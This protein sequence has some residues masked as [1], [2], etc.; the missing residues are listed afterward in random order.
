MLD[1]MELLRKKEQELVRV[2]RQVEALR[3][4]APLLGEE[5]QTTGAITPATSREKSN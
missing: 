4:A 3:I 5:D 1:V 2:K